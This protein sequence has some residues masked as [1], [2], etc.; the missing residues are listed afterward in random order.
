MAIRAPSASEL[1]EDAD[2]ARE[3]LGVTAHRLRNHLTPSRLFDEWAQSSGVKTMTAQ[4]ALG[5][6][7][8]RYPIP[9]VLVGAAM[10]FLAYSAVHRISAHEREIDLTPNPTGEDRGRKPGRASEIVSSLAESAA[11]V[12]VENAKA[13]AASRAERVGGSIPDPTPRPIFVSLL[14]LLLAAAVRTTL[15]RST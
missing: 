7:A 2:R 4:R 9:T 13:Q 5:T 14:Q 1:A 10:G 11:N 15:P 12:L 8:R 3:Q 6:A